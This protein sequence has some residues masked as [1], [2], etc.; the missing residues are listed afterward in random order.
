MDF[1]GRKARLNISMTLKVIGMLLVFEGIFMLIPIIVSLVYDEMHEIKPFAI[2][3][4]ITLL[5]GLLMRV[6][7]PSGTSDLGKREGFMLT[8]MVW[9]FFSLFAML[10]FIY[11]STRMSVHDA[12]FEAMS[13][14]TTTGA[15]TVYDIT[16]LT[17]TMLFYRCLIQWLGGMGIILFTLSIIPML[18]SSGGMQMFNAETTGITHDK[19]QP[20]ISQTAKRLWG[21]YALLTVICAVL[22]WFS[23]MNF[24]DC[25][26]H[27]MG[28]LSTGGFSTTPASIDVWHSVYVKIV[29]A[30]FMFLAGV[31]FITNYRLVCGN[32]KSVWSNEAFR[33]YV[34]YTVFFAVLIGIIHLIQGH[35]TNLENG[36]VDP[37][38]QVISSISTTGYIV[39]GH[40]SW[41]SSTILIFYILMFIGSC[42]GST[43][44]G[45]KVDRIIYLLKNVRNEIYR[46]LHPNSIVP[47]KY[48]GKPVSPELVNKVMA[49]I[50]LYFLIVIVG[51]FAMTLFG[52][53]LS[54]AFVASFSCISN[55]GLGGDFTGGCTYALIPDA[56]KWIL[57][58]IMLIG[59]LEL[60]TVMVLVST[61]FWKR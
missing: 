8:S 37:V 5:A 55:A 2:S 28:T 58:F 31:S 11:G 45:V 43:T 21:C 59:R 13:G 49:F 29:I 56:A 32:F 9:I 10:P 27:A 7:L 26:C 14:F 38:F 6:F 25:I 22:L 51:A 60:F 42:A 46:V 54:D 15:S 19:I 61:G 17:K 35:A 52:T 24:F 23:P 41:G 30:A 33:F 47:V 39:E 36:I 53:S 12:F 57:S 4:G 1:S 18:N 44:G 16:A 48:N 40:N 20:R 3:A 50:L 34:K